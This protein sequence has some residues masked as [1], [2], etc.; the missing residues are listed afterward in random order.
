MPATVQPHELCSRNAI[1]PVAL[2]ALAEVEW[3]HSPTAACTPA[4]SII[5]SV[6]RLLG[7][8]L[9]SRSCG[10]EAQII[11]NGSSAKVKLAN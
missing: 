8:T 11:W 4:Q 1:T 2:Q 7:R 10:A 3:C 6:I 9:R 5:T